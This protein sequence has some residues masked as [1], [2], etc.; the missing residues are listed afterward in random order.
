MPEQHNSAYRI[1]LL[2]TEAIRYSRQGQSPLTVWAEVFKLPQK[3]ST[4]TRFLVADL[5]KAMYEELNRI[6]TKAHRTISLSPGRYNDAITEICEALSPVYIAAGWEN[7]TSRFT[8]TN[9]QA[10]LFLS[11][12][13]PDNEPPI[14]ED[15]IVSLLEKIDELESILNELS[16]E[17]ADFIRYHIN[18]IKRAVYE[19]RIVGEEIFVRE[20]HK[21]M[22]FW[23]QNQGNEIPELLAKEPKFREAFEKFGEIFADIRHK[24]ENVETLMKIYVGVKLL[25]TVVGT[26]LLP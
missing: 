12:L 18:V 21:I 9:L 10:L 19:Y 23:Y 4:Q 6:R 14:D 8:A 1:H 26:K 11:E 17:A 16:I 3:D 7:C 13:L 5:V 20:L 25:D 2:L 22:L 15:F 24:V